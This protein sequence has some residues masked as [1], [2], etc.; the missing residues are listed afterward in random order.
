MAHVNEGSHGVCIRVAVSA[1]NPSVNVVRKFVHLLDIGEN[2]YAEEFGPCL[3][4]SET[5]RIVFRASQIV[6]FAAGC[7]LLATVDRCLFL[8][9]WPH[10]S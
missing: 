3:F 4:S 9:S 6:S 10:N 1:V 2:D 7:P 5:E 8:R